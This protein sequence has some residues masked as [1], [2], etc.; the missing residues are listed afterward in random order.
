M[1]GSARLKA[2]DDITVRVVGL[3][4]CGRLVERRCLR[5][6][7]E[8]LRKN[9]EPDDS[10]ARVYK[11]K[12]LRLTS[13]QTDRQTDTQSDTHKERKREGECDATTNSRPTCFAD[14][15]WR[16]A[17]SNT[18]VA[19]AHTKTRPVGRNLPQRGGGA[20]CPI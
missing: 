6:L 20:L 15:H 18:V 17:D 1:V 13:A 16:R 11:I 9:S 7:S 4:N 2:R 3:A 12:M 14:L 5:L 8:S 10:E 19:C